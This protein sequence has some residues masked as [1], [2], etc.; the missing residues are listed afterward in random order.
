MS[1]K[2]KAKE[3]PEFVAAVRKYDPSFGRICWKRFE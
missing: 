2:N 1:G 3:V